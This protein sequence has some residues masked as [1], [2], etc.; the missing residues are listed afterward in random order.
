M[1][2]ENSSASSHPG[3]TGSRLSV[4]LRMSYESYLGILLVGSG[5]RV[6]GLAS[7]LVVLI[8]LGR[9][10]GKAE[11]GDLMAAFGFYRVVAIAVGT[12]ASLV[13][14]FHVSRRPRDKELEV[15]LHR[16]S[17]LLTAAISIVVALIGA[18]SAPLIARALGKPGLEVWFVHL[19]P[20]AVFNSLL[21]IATGALEGRSRI[22]HSIVLGEV[23][24]NAVRIVLLPLVVLAGLPDIYIA[25]VLTLSVL[26]P[27]LFAAPRLFDR[28]IG[29]VSAWKQWDYGYSGKFVVATLFANQLAAVDILVMSVLFSSETVGDYAI[30]SRIAAMFSFF[31]LAMLKRFAPR[32]GEILAKGDMAALRSEVEVCRRL[33]IGC[34]AF[35]IAGILFIAPWI[36]PLFGNFGGSLGFLTLLAIG[37]F[38]SS[39]YATSDRLLIIAGHANVALTLTASSFAVLTITPFVTA[40]WLGPIAVPAAMIASAILF[41]PIVAVRVRQLFGIQ[42][43]ALPDL[44]LMVCGSA[45]LAIAAIN[46]SRL[47]ALGAC[48]VLCLIGVYVLATAIRQSRSAPGGE[49]ATRPV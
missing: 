20:L 29:G 15:R 34:G 44:A 40:P 6:F 24:P 49:G 18:L 45:M 11:F 43:L 21:L 38:V 48:G 3:L 9:M 2:A 41:N 12:G 16:F 27:W 33:T 25:H 19:A 28:S 5:A 4:W 14:L 8:I 39:F 46:G 42:T 30:A 10:L 37:A 36:I 23:A 47:W 35:T 1:S 13:V 7:Q 31:Q 17:A 22:T 26:L 32:A